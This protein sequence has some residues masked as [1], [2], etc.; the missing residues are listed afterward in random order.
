MSKGGMMEMQLRCDGKCIYLRTDLSEKNSM[1]VIGGSRMGKTYFASNLARDLMED[2]NTI[3]LVDLGEKWSLSDKE[4]LLKVGAERWTI[5]KEGLLLAFSSDSDLIGCAGN[6]LSA[7]SCRSVIADIVLKSVFKELL[8]KNRSF[9]FQDVFKKLKTEPEI[10]TDRE[11]KEWRRKLY[12]Y[13]D[14]SGEIPE[15][16]FAKDTDCDSSQTSMIWELSGYDKRYVQMM[17]YL[18]LYHL[19]CEKRNR[20]QR[21]GSDKDTFLIIDEFQNLDFGRKSILGT[22]LTEGQKYGLNMILITQFL[23][24]NFSEPIIRQMKQGGFRF[25]FR[26]TEEEAIRISRLIVYGSQKREVMYR[27]LTKLPR[28]QCMMMGPHSVGT[29]QR[30][31]EDFRFV[32]I[33]TNADGSGE[34]SC[35]RK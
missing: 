3:H 5:K 10:K 11:Q 12:G 24:D 16:V 35:I 1:I 19:L 33:C 13:F 21:K 8:K 2:R 20:F 4:R 22:C 15:I 23:D 7:F 32:Q 30:V 29:Q 14:D 6:I 25:Y 9:T 27:K 17:T 26:L 34:S 18:I 28:G 31:T